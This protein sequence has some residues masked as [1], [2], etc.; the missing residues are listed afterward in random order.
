MAPTK[1][2]GKAITQPS[3]SSTSHGPPSPFK[4]PNE[5]LEAF[6]EG[7]NPKHIY[8]THVDSHPAEFKKK[9]FLVPI[10]INLGVIAMFAIRLWW[11]WPWYW[12][13]LEFAFGYPN[14]FTIAPG[15][16]WSAIAWEV[17]KRAVTLLFDFLLIIFVWPWPIEFIIGGKE[18]SPIRWRRAVGFREKEIYVRRSREWDTVLGDIFKDE[19]SMKIFV[20]QV[21]AATSPLKQEQKTGYLLMDGHWDLDWHDM[22]DAHTLVDRNIIALDAFKSVV[23]VHHQD[24]G[25]LT[26]DIKGGE[27]VEEDDK[28]RQVFAFRDALTGMGKE[29]LFYRWVELV[30]FEA[31]QPGGFGPEK[32][33][34]AAK[35]IRELFEAQ[36]VN[37]DELWKEAVGAE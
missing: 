20:G 23:L 15:S 7:L 16:T 18:G 30:Q 36:G 22:V 19:D 35:K 21:R 29:D 24:Y 25:W 34:A 6:I 31:T 28:R 1:R 27:A 37:F 32:Q 8:I 26:Y 5:V 14:E 4:K 12:K 2:K 10:G 13:L 17:G 33:E 9:M 3:Q 11:I